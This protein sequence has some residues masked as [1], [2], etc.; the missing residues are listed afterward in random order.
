MPNLNRLKYV[1]T[2][3]V[4]AESLN[5][6]VEKPIYLPATATGSLPIELFA[7]KVDSGRP[8]LSLFNVSVYFMADV[9]KDTTNY[10]TIQI[11]NRGPAGAGTDVIASYTT[12]AATATVGKYTEQLFTVDG[13]KALI[14][15][16]SVVTVN[17]T[18]N[19]TGFIPNAAVIIR[20]TE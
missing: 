6:S 12:N 8:I 15:A 5:N 16:G 7:L 3:P 20:F 2:Q 19:G 1:G 4:N 14:A 11:I 9:T 10:F 18:K 17:V 13:T